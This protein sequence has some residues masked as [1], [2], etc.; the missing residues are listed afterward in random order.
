MVEEHIVKGKRNKS[1]SGSS[2]YQ[3][4]LGS[5]NKIYFPMIICEAIVDNDK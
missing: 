5:E 2:E 3:F 4:H 1:A